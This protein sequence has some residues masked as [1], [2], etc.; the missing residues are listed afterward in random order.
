MLRAM[1]IENNN[2][3]ETGGDELV[4]RWRQQ[5]QGFLWLDLFPQDGPEDTP[6]LREFGIHP[7]AIQDAQRPRHPPKFEVFDDVMFVLLRG[8]SSESDSIDVD[9]IQIALFM[10]KNFLIT[11]HEKLSPSINHYW[12]SCKKDADALPPEPHLIGWYI[13]R[14]AASRYLDLMN[15]FEPRLWEM[16]EK[17]FRRPRDTLLNQLTAN[18]TSLRHLSRIFNYHVRV[19]QGLRHHYEDSEQTRYLN[20]LLNDL[21]EQYDR[22]NGLAHM[23]YDVTGDLID[24]YL[25]TSSHRLN[26]TMRL[27]TVITAIFV[28]L[29][30]ITGLYGMNFDYMPELHSRNGFYNTVAMMVSIAVLLLVFFRHKR[31]L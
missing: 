3:I 19:F 16:E 23:F 20:H 2:R 10:G 31:W 24:G 28:P 30:F 9:T 7:L 6:W 18:R 25:S 22:L 15:N 26:N 1:L 5:P 11:R 27:L 4:R 13:S 8:L 17:M 14:Y 29:N 21:Y 12:D